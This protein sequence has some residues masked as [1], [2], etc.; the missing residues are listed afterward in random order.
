MSWSPEKY[1]AALRFA[2]CAHGDQRMP[3]EEGLPYVVHLAMVAAEVIG[4]LRV[5]VVDDQALAVQCALLHDTLEDTEVQYSKVVA[6]FGERVADGV[7]ALSKD[8]RLP[9]PD[10]MIDSLRR[11]RLQPREVWM[12][13][14]ADRVTNLQPP[15]SHWDAPKRR[16]YLAEAQVI[17][18]QLGSA[19]EA[20]TSR[21]QERMASYR[22][23]L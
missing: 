19:S 8:R 20:L 22:A 17:L 11:I 6:T 4:A 7:S 21:M 16:A 2:A 9:K 15:P 23:Y 13:K 10:R 3:G 12:V 14:L 1:V 18:D 5:E